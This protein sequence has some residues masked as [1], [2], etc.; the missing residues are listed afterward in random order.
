VTPPFW[1]SAFLDFPA[2]SF[3]PGVAFWR[4][5][6]G[7]GLSPSRGDHQEF[8]TLVPPEGDDYLR[9]QRVQDG[10]GGIH[11]DLHVTDPRTA[12]DQA[13]ALGAHEVAGQG[14][15]SRGYV[16]LHSPGGL[17]FCMVTHPASR[18]PPP[19]SWPDGSRS[20]VDQVCLDIP[21]GGYAEECAFWSA[22]TSWELSASPTA[23]EFSRLARPA[24]IPLRFLLQR[25]EESSGPVRAHLDLACDDRVA[26][27]N[28]H[29]MLGATVLSE[30][31]HWTVLRD[32]VGTTYCVTDRNPET[33]VLA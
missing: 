6:T 12:A 7:F 29:A 26:E 13:V 10:P 17:T 2:S 5:I 30:R 4:E 15:A 1:A 33:G 11:L 23:P 24:G 25:L 8:A 21:S 9:V 14:W 31:A 28:R 19:A 18:R 22:L 32:P 27:V 16:V 20:L 3:A